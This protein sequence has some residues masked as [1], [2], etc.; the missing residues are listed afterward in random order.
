MRSRLA[1]AEI[2]PN[3][4]RQTRNGP[5]WPLADGTENPRPRKRTRRTNAQIA[6]D[7]EAAR[8]AAEA[9]EAVA[10]V[11]VQEEE[12]PPP[13]G[14]LPAAFRSR[15][16]L[17]PPYDVGRLDFECEFCRAKHWISEARSG[18]NQQF[19]LLQ[20]RGWGLRTVTEPPRR[21]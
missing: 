9:V 4:P 18:S 20:V 13:L 21:P 15:F 1:L 3:A 7:R 5:R 8:V 2:D 10:A 6:A 14:P 17:L 19:S 16:T 12:P 11:E